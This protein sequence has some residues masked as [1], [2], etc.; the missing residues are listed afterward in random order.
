[1]GYESGANLSRF[2]YKSRGFKRKRLVT[3]AE[4]HD[5]ERLMYKNLNYGNSSNSAHNIK[6]LDISL[7]KNGSFRSCGTQNS[8]I[9]SWT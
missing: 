3:Y 8:F 4:S 1:M 5:E 6:T 7:K 2:D 9:E